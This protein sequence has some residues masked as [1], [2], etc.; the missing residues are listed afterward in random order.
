MSVEQAI[1]QMEFLG[2]DFFIFASIEDKEV[3]VIYRRKDGKYGL[4]LPELS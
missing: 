4:I 2:H 3:N 1:D